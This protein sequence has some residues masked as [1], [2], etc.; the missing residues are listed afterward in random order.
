MFKNYLKDFPKK[1]YADEF[2]NITTRQL[3]SHLGGIR[4]YNK[5]DCENY[6]VIIF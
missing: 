4:H 5:K 1:K 2:V 3:L 6:E